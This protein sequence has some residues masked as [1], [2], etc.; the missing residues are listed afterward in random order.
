MLQLGALQVTRE[1][2]TTMLCA[3]MF[4]AKKQIALENVMQTEICVKTRFASAGTCR[5]HD[6]QDLDPECALNGQ[7]V[8]Y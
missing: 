3:T 6:L 7:T 5:K 4:R 2:Y 8:F 1:R